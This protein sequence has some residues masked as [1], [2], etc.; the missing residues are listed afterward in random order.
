M[1]SI[2]HARL[3]RF[4]SKGLAS[5]D[6]VIAPQAVP[7][8]AGGPA[9]VESLAVWHSVL[10]PVQCAALPSSLRLN[11]SLGCL[12]A[13]ASKLSPCRHLHLQ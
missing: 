2:Y 4:C 12:R 8:T 7:D 1:M 11:M 10:D 5:G 13:S 6:I 3:H 9:A